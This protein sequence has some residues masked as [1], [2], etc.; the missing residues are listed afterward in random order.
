MYLFGE[1]MSLVDSNSNYVGDAFWPSSI[2]LSSR[3]SSSATPAGLPT[4]YCPPAPAWKKKARSPAP[5]RRIQRLY[6]VFEPLKGS[7]PDWQI[8]QDVANRLGADWHYQHPSEI[9][10][11]IASLTPLFAGVTY[12]RLEGYKSLQWPVAADGTDEPL[13]YTKGFNFPGRQSQAVSRVASPNRRNS[14]MPNSTCI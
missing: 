1:D 9:Y 12:E 6:Q 8:I 2:S 14:R 11:E 10:R 4:W 3:I 13:L 5:R 7:R